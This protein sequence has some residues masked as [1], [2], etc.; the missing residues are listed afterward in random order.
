MSTHRCPIVKIENILP[1]PNADKLEIISIPGTMWQTIQPIGAFKIGDLGIWIEPD[2]VVPTTYPEFAWLKKE[3]EERHRVKAVRLRGEPSYGLLIPFDANTAPPV[4]DMDTNQPTDWEGMNMMRVYDIK[5]WEPPIQV[6][7]AD[8]LKGEW[9]S[10]VIPKMDMESVTNFPDILVPGETVIATEKLHGTS[11]RYLFENGTFY[12]GSRTR[13]LDPD[14]AHAWAVAN[15]R[16]KIPPN[17]NITNLP[18]DGVLWG[19]EQWCR[20]H[21]GV[22]LFGEVIGVTGGFKYGLKLPEF[23]AFGA[24]SLAKGWHMPTDT[25]AYGVKT[26]PMVYA[27]PYDLDRIRP[28]A[29]TDT[30]V[31]HAPKGHMMEGVVIQP[32]P[33]RHDSTVGN[34]MLKLHSVR[35]WLDKHA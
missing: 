2:M 17:D 33:P 28:L 31:P 9:P 32:F 23:R 24:W 27:G 29:E 8:G 22:T 10:S 11:A 7:G 35:Y 3:G 15:K 21:E 30:G 18:V 20:M 26:V 34:V 19:I 16:S 25:R 14:A 4:Y 13:W 6:S 12:M 1:H 5:R